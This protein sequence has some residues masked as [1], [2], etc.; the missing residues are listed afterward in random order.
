VDAML[1]ILRTGCQWRNLP[2]CFP[3]WQSVY[4][5]FHTWKEQD[6][7]SIINASVNRLDRKQ[8]GRNEYPS[9]FCIDS[10]SVKL[11][12]MIGGDR[13]LDPNKKVNGRKRQFLVDSGGRL[14]HTTVH[15]ASIA[16]GFGG[17]ELSE[18]IFA[19]NK[20]LK[21]VFG[22]QA[23]NGVFADRMDAM[24]LIYQKASKP[25]S[26]KGFVPVKGRWVVERSIS[27]TT[28]FRRLVKDYERTV[29]SSEFWLILANIQI[30]IQR[31]NPNCQI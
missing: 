3:K 20:R 28:M 9:I 30:M 5:Y 12:P 13:G 6:V 25:E 11:S 31:I 10:Q 27:W 8:E 26:A 21:K 19:Q 14:W 4:W 29:S 17:L 7:F 22:D 18:A 16:D 23:Y 24:G 15:A 2:T 1:Y